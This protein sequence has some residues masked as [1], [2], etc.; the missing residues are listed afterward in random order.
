MNLLF[1]FVCEGKQDA[2]PGAHGMNRGKFFDHHLKT[3]SK[4]ENWKRAKKMDGLILVY[5]NNFRSDLTAFMKTL[6]MNE[7]SPGHEGAQ[8]GL[9]FKKVKGEFKFAGIETIP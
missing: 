5:E 3:I 2:K 6:K 7:Y 9:Y 1:C 4:S 8:L